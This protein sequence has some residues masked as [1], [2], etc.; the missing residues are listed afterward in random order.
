MLPRNGGW[1]LTSKDLFRIKRAKQGGFERV[2]GGQQELLSFCSL[3]LIDRTTLPDWYVI[4][5]EDPKE[6]EKVTDRLRLNMI[7]IMGIG[8]L[9]LM[10]LARLLIF[11]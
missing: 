1:S 11:R 5:V 10:I 8:I 7:T 9:A 3:K 6:L 4:V 2:S